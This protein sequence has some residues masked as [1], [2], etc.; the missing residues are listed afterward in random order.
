MT[1]R[2]HIAETC[3]CGAE[4]SITV[5]SRYSST[6]GEAKSRVDEWRAE[7]THKP[8]TTSGRTYDPIPTGATTDLE[9]AGQW[10]HDTRPPLGFTG[11]N[12]R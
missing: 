2:L 6:L 9:R 12:A 10:D 5:E 4:F 3:A 1:E 7:H 11:G 8:A